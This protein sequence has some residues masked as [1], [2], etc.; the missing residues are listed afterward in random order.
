MNAAWLERCSKDNLQRL[1]RLQKRSAKIILDAGPMCPS[2]PALFNKLS[3]FHFIGRSQSCKVRV[4][5]QKN[6]YLMKPQS[7]L[8][9]V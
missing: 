7:I 2:V 1:L 4:G 3:G 6:I 5:I 9:I 8:L